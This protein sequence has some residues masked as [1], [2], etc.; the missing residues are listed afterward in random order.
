MRK[1]KNIFKRVRKFSSALGPGVISGAADDDPSGIGTYT[2]AGAQFG[3]RLLWT[4][5]F[6]WPLMA[7]VQFTCARIGLVTGEG[8]AA[9]LQKKFPKPVLYFLCFALFF[10]NTLNVG[11][12]LSAMAD[13]AEMLFGGSSHFYVIGFA[14]I[15]AVATI[16]LSYEKI[17]NLLKWLALSLFSYVFTAIFLHPQWKTVFKES[18]TIRVPTQTLEWSMI[19]A[20]FGTTISP[21]LFYWQTSLEVEEQ[22]SFERNVHE[23]SNRILSKVLFNRKVDVIIGTFFSNIVMFF[24]ILTTALTLHENGFTNIETTQQASEVL[25]PLAGKFS[26]LLYTMGIIGV[27]FLAIPT[28]TGSAAYAIAETFRWKE[29]LNRKFAQ[30]K[31]FYMVIVLSTVFAVIFDFSDVPPLKA[32]YWSSVGNGVLAP[33]ILFGIYSI[34]RDE[35]IMKNQ[36]S[37]KLTQTIVGLTLILMVGATLGMFFL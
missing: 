23:T 22:K 16:K 17:S 32:L 31:A 29:G 21:Y 14:V 4:S 24:I 10:A 20:I 34:M 37:S 28:L 18:F 35:K 36:P 8:L 30:A 13:A 33:F 19:V 3:T 11:A 27:G 2:V 1:L 5:F 6:T 7:V 26:A 12:D 9:N 15:I 25:V